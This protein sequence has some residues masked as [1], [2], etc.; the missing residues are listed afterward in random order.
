MQGKRTH[1][2][3]TRV[4]STSREIPF[5]FIHRLRLRCTLLEVCVVSFSRLVCE[6]QLEGAERTTACNVQPNWL[7]CHRAAPHPSHIGV[8]LRILCCA[9]CAG[10]GR[11]PRGCA[12]GGVARVSRCRALV[13]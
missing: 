5:G 6:L 4:C 12:R 8:K 2:E 10:R 13:G 9:M 11:D 3:G 1:G 7:V